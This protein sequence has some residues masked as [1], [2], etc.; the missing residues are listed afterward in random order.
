[1]NDPVFLII[2]ALVVLLNNCITCYYWNH[3]RKLS[4]ELESSL[5][6]LAQEIMDQKYQEVVN[7][8][9]LE[10]NHK[11]MYGDSEGS[12]TYSFTTDVEILPTPIVNMEEDDSFEFS[13]EEVNYSIDDYPEGDDNE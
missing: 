1:M 5:L 3:Y 13:L 8:A 4:E 6:Q 10:L 11:L 9:A 7:E 12:K 2:L